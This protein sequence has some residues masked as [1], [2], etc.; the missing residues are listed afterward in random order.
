M[1]TIR[2]LWFLFSP[3]ERLY[4]LL[5]VPLMLA[6]AVM[7]VIGVGA[8][9]AFVAVLS[10]DDASAQPRALRVALDL[11]GA[12]GH[13]QEVLWAAGALMV[14][15][16][17]KNA[18][19]A[20]N[21]YLAIRFVTGRSVQL[22]NRLFRAY[23]YAPY[24]FHLQRNTAKLIHNSSTESGR[25]VGE[26][27]MPAIVIV[28]EAL[29]VVAMVALLLWMEPGVSAVMVTVVGGACFWFFRLVKRKMADLSQQQHVFYG[30]QLQSA[31]QALG[32]VK[33][34]KVAG[35]EEFF[36][37]EFATNTSEAHRLGVFKHVVYELPRMFVETMAVAAMLGVA[38]YFIL[39]GRPPSDVVPTLTLLGIS[40]IRFV[41]SANR[42]VSATL[43][44]RW[45]SSAINA[46]YTDLVAL[47]SPAN[48]P[49]A[50]VRGERFSKAIELEGL[51]HTY[52]GSATRSLDKVSLQIPRGSAVGF[53]GPSGAGKTTLVDVILGLLTPTEGRIL[54][55]GVDLHENA[56]AWQRQVGYV[57]QTIYLADDSIRR[58]V[59]FGL[60][61]EEID[62]V[63]VRRAIEAAQLTDLI[64]KLP[65]GL[66][67]LV[68][69]RGVRLSG[70]Q[71][72]RIGIARALYHDPSVL[73]LDEA[74]SS[75]DTETER[76][77]VDA[78]EHLRGDRTILVIAHRLTTV[79]NCDR[80]FFLR[81][82]R[83]EASGTYAEL[84]DD[85]RHFRS[86]AVASA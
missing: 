66:S 31:N 76:S 81:D 10:A 7:E 52:A 5:L 28:R 34:I 58:N 14:V 77:I 40:A 3:R 83:I 15:F 74:T 46:V 33:E 63:R 41:P 20:L 38:A 78:L 12:S 8:I 85:N 18:F 16:I 82:G 48:R 60:R 71:R 17:V 2:R 43:G 64:E 79:Q 4:A 39:S 11:L 30:K 49:G 32:G 21:S 19:L 75:V 13:E 35:R 45:G 42:L 73:V 72:Q 51:S 61:D 84:F 56:R 50:A 59:A 53:V 36:L 24:S 25:A 27:L 86:L 65:D 80:L 57:P 37:G 44:L 55:D 47:E 68:G 29:V 67:T 70:G 54:V 26:G 69:E 23:M 22:G 62:D 6:S 9:P 1:T